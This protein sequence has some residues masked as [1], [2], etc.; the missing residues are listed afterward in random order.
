MRTV[1]DRFWEK[2]DITPSCWNW[3]AAVSVGYGRFGY[4]G[5]MRTAHRVAWKLMTGSYPPESLDHLCQNKLC[6][7]PDHLEP[8]SAS[9]NSRRR[10]GVWND[11]CRNG[12]VSDWRRNGST[13]RMC[14]PCANAR[15]RANDA[16]KRSLREN[17]S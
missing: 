13:K 16:R 15:D 8:V 2:V 17:N 4:E 1:E 9:E 6:V 7:N 14:R 11:T 5:F 3:K 12:H 10:S